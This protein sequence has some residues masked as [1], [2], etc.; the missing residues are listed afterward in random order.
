MNRAAPDARPRYLLPGEENFQRLLRAALELQAKGDELEALWDTAAPLRGSALVVAAGELWLLGELRKLHQGGRDLL[1]AMGE[2]KNDSGPHLAKLEAK[3]A[4]AEWALLP[5]LRELI[6]AKARL[7]A[8]LV[9]A[10]EQRLADSAAAL[11]ALKEAVAEAARVMAPLESEAKRLRELEDL[12]R[13]AER[14][15]RDKQYGDLPGPVAKLSAY[16]EKDHGDALAGVRQKQADAAAICR[17]ADLLFLRSPRDDRGRYDYTVLLRTPSEPGTQ[18]VNVQASTT[19]VEQ[20]RRE[21]LEAVK[22]FT[23]QLRDAFARDLGAPPR[24]AP[25]GPDVAPTLQ[26]IGELMYRLFMPE[27]MQRYVDETHC[28]LTVTTN[29]LEL[30]WELM[31]QRDAASGAGREDGFL[32]L[33]RPVARLPM[34]HAFPRRDRGLPARRGRLRFLLIHSDPRGDL[35]GAGREIAAI[36]GDLTRDWGERIE[37][38]VL[39]AGEVNGR[40]INR[41]LRGGEFDVIH[42]AGHAYA[43][44]DQGDLG[45]LLLEGGEVFFA[46]KVRRLL[47][48]RPLVFLNAC[49][50]GAPG[51][52]PAEGGP[53]AYARAEGLASAF[54]YG[55]AV[56]CIGSLWPISDAPAASFATAFYRHVLE[57]NVIG[58]AMRLARCDLRRQHKDDPTWAAFVLYGNPTYRHALS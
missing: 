6:E 5:E 55:G 2:S 9:G 43:D 56:A 22:G 35:P 23:G 17:Q 16:R 21:I 51:G 45:G 30:P 27:E 1:S 34:G 25:G 28:S 14:A 20:D 38:K 10:Y 24:E 36:R 15:L 11:G 8:E 40:Q 47:E 58:E 7:H 57:G 46:Q 29:D 44:D 31:F 52:A 4:A 33:R 48:G 42:Y 39:G 18:G 50:S 41:I 13:R 26:D 32:C 19:L 3:L 49:Q 54:I 53:G 37:V 12:Q